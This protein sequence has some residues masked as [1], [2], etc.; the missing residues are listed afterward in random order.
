MQR[1]AKVVKCSA[2]LEYLRHAARH[3]LR[4]ID[5]AHGRTTGAAGLHS[6]RARIELRLWVWR[7]WWEHARHGTRGGPRGAGMGAIVG[8]RCVYCWSSCALRTYT[9]PLLVSQ[10]NRPSTALQRA[11]AGRHAQYERVPR[12][13]TPISTLSCMP[14]RWSRHRDESMCSPHAAGRGRQTWACHPACAHWCQ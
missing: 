8:S 7:C 1:C 6:C 3:H 14:I 10:P 9:W 11:N 12:I 5:T 2:R 4:A 13:K